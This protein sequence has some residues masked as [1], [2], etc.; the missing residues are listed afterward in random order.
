M[1]MALRYKDPKKT[2]KQGKNRAKTGQKQGKNRGKKGPKVIRKQRENKRKQ[3][4]FPGQKD[5]KG[6][7]SF[8]KGTLSRLVGTPCCKEGTQCVRDTP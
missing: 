6:A 1:Y 7:L 4:K 8:R 2:Q 5:L 3:A